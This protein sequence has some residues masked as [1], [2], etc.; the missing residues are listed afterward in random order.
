M[1]GIPFNTKKAYRKTDVCHVCDEKFKKS[2]TYKSG[3]K[4]ILKIYDDPWA[5]EAST[6]CVHANNEDDYGTCLDKLTDT[7]WGD[8]R[9][10]VCA[11]CGRTI[12]RQCP[13]NGWRSYVKERDGEEI[14][15]SCY[16]TS[17]LADGHGRESFEAGRI[18]GDFFD[19]TEIENNGWTPAAGLEHYFVSGN[20]S[21]Q[22]L[23]EDILKLMDGG[24][25]VL[26]DYGSMAIGGGEGS[27]SVH[28]K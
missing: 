16:Q 6:V 21:A 14:C 12:I 19:G 20:R 13:Y 11:D 25:K 8:F 7:S 4:M 17:I 26:V 3:A 10:F 15:V 27:V 23:S 1:M 2:E 5:T 9:F 18:A 22:S 24:K 28:V